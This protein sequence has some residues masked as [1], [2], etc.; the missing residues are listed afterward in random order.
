LPPAKVSEWTLAPMLG[1]N[2]K[3]MGDLTVACLSED[4]FVLMGS[5]FLQSFHMRWF[6]Q[7]GAISTAGLRVEN[8]TDTHLGFAISGPNSRK[9][10]QKLTSTDLSNEAFKFMSVAQID[11]GFSSAIVG[12]VSV[13]GELGYEITVPAD[14]QIAL[15]RS[16]MDAGKEFALRD[17]GGYALTSLRMAWG[18]EFTPEFT[19][20]LERTEPVH[21]VRQAHQLHWQGACPQGT[22]DRT[23]PHVGWPCD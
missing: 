7:N 17:I 15:Y 9:L 1:H 21:S 14:Q 3:L 13:T 23:Q 22:P 6:I 18:R 12:R 10:L 20:L 16:L 2:G 5:G 4:R 19:A 8:I 11:V